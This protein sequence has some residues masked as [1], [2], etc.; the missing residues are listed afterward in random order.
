MQR[1]L[2]IL[3]D[4]IAVG[5]VSVP[6]VLLVRNRLLAGRCAG[7]LEDGQTRCKGGVSKV[8]IDR[9]CPACC[10]RIHND[11]CRKNFL[12]PGES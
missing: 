5:A 2:V 12:Q 3:L 11:Q 10:A 8:C 9:L 6:A 7:V 4:L 1:L